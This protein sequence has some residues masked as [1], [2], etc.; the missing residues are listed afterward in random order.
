MK[1]NRKFVNAEEAVSPVIAVILMVAITVVLAATLFVLLDLYGKEQ[2]GL[3]L[4]GL[5]QVEDS[6]KLTVSSR[7]AGADWSNIR[8]KVTSCTQQAASSTIIYLGATSPYQND[9]ATAAAG[10]ALNAAAAAGAACGAQADPGIQVAT[11]VNTDVQPENFLDFC[12]GPTTLTT[13]PTDVV[14]AVIDFSSGNSLGTF[15][16]Q[17]VAICAT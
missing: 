15:T 10:G 9:E 17:S 12:A 14:V 8:V 2:K 6:D 5:T 4:I 16:F 1:A 11:A 13:A 7:Q 3:V